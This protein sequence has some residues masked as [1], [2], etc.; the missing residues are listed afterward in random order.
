MFHY[1]FRNFPLDL[2][3]RA[4]GY[5]IYQSFSCILCS[6]AFMMQVNSFIQN[7]L[8]LKASLTWQWSHVT[9]HMHSVCMVIHFKLYN[10]L[11][12]QKCAHT[13]PENIEWHAWYWHVYFYK[14][15]CKNCCAQ[16]R[17]WPAYEANI[18]L[19]SLYLLNFLNWE[20]W[21]SANSAIIKY[22]TKCL[23]STWLKCW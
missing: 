4:N 7:L 9:L 1:M 16:W 23:W 19:P 21:A 17:Q 15:Y 12:F 11:S 2:I 8:Q 10:L 13:L 22:K 3:P 20:M 14:E 6:I 18:L 5:Q